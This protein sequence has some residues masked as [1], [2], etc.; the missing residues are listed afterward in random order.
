[1]T[2]SHPLPSPTTDDDRWV[3]VNERVRLPRAELTFRATRAGGPGGQHVNTSSTRVELLW[4][5]ARSAA[6]DD[7]QRT[8]VVERL[9]EPTGRSRALGLNTPP[10][11]VTNAPVAEAHGMASVALE[12]ALGG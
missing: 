4:N 10:G 8:L 1:M 11:A 12:T 3:V 6:L 9:A 2:E 7:S 5:P